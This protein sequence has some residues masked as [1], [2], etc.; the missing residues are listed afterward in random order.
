M[1]KNGKLLREEVTKV[2]CHKGLAGEPP[3]ERRGKT[4]QFEIEEGE[5]RGLMSGLIREAE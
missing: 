1:R 5:R 4:W 2:C 3:S